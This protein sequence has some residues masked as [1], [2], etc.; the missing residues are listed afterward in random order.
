MLLIYIG[1]CINQYLKLKYDNGWIFAICLLLFIQCVVLQHVTI[2]MA[3]NSYQDLF[4]LCIG[5]CCAIYVLGYVARKIEKTYIGDFLSLMGRESLYLMALHIL[6]FFICSSLLWKMDLISPDDKH[7]MY[8]YCREGHWGILF[9]YV[10]F[11]IFVP[12]AIIFVY[13]Q[14]RRIALFSKDG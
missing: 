3:K 8:T 5:S 1:M 10:L 2:V 14:I 13:R 12:L 4:Q 6:G 9:L 11:G 7:G